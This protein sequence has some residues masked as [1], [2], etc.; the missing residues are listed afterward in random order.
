MFFSFFFEPL[1]DITRFASKKTTEKL[2]YT[3]KST[4]FAEY[5][6]KTKFIKL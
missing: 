6:V 2:I 1:H 4:T 5:S 3:K